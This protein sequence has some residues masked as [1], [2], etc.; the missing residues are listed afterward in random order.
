MPGAQ[1]TGALHPVLGRARSSATPSHIWP[2]A[3]IEGPRRAP[4]KTDHKQQSSPRNR[5]GK[6]YRHDLARMVHGV[7][8]EAVQETRRGPARYRTDS[9]RE[10]TV[11][12]SAKRSKAKNNVPNR[13]PQAH[14]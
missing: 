1:R 9:Y 13:L 2:G 7:L 12:V 4:E 6:R 10:I 14:F 11:A 8:P 3:R 5:K